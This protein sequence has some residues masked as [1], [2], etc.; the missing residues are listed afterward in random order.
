MRV[1][2]TSIVLR[3]CLKPCYRSDGDSDALHGSS[4]FAFDPENFFC[5]KV[6]LDGHIYLSTLNHRDSIYCVRPQFVDCGG[7]SCC[8]GGGYRKLLL[9]LVMCRDVTRQVSR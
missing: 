2:P 3:S 1:L 7:R 8:Q 4:G 6:K 5:S 9:L